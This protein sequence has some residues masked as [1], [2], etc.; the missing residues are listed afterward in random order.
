MPGINDPSF[1]CPH[2]ACQRP[3]SLKR[4]K[5]GSRKGR[6]YLL[7]DQALDHPQM[8]NHWYWWAPGVA[9]ARRQRTLEALP[10]APTATPTTCANTT[11]CKGCCDDHG[12]CLCHVDTKSTAHTR[13]TALPISR[14]ATIPIARTATTATSGFDQAFLNAIGTIFR[15]YANTAPI[16]A[17]KAAATAQQIQDDYA[18][19][20]AL[21][22]PL[23]PSPTQSEEEEYSMLLTAPSS[24][25]TSSSPFPLGLPSSPA[26]L[27]RRCPAQSR[28]SK[29]K[30]SS[31]NAGSS[32]PSSTAAYI[33]VIELFDTEDDDD[34]VQIIRQGRLFKREPVTPKRRRLSP[35]A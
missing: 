32:S 14:A 27:T 9:P 33:E 20:L 1:A 15:T 25:P 23:P 7:C 31:Q 35:P 3:L 34:N 17:S 29:R 2:P 19:A 8:Q 10:P 5:A 30:T 24:P 6:Y 18:L 22:T 4:C 16:A 13:S 28:P 11:M 21:A 26:A 12:G